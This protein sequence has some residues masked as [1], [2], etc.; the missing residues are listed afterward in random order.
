MDILIEMACVDTPGVRRKNKGDIVNS[1]PYIRQWG[2][3]TLHDMLHFPSTSH[4]E[5]VYEVL[6]YTP[7]YEGGLIPTVDFEFVLNLPPEQQEFARNSGINHRTQVYYKKGRKYDTVPV[8]VSKKRFK[9]RE[10]EYLGLDQ[11]LLEDPLVL[12][13]PFLSRSDIVAYWFETSSQSDH[14]LIERGG[15]YFLKRIRRWKRRQHIEVID[16]KIIQYIRRKEPAIEVLTPD[17]PEREII[18][19]DAGAMIDNNSRIDFD[20]D[21]DD[22]IVVDKFD[23]QSRRGFKLVRDFLVD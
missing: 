2:W 9:I 15:R 6:R 4:Y 5:R 22:S 11:G 12:Y 20:L 18:C 21:V 19:E 16:G 10:T 13:Q 8:V 1:R 7:L 23:G 3:E 17:A 14:Q